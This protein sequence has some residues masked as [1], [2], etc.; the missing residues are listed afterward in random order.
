MKRQIHE[1]SLKLVIDYFVKGY[2]LEE[3]E[4]ICS[5]EY[6]ID[7]G[8]DKMFVALWTKKKDKDADK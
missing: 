8:K 6:Y 1:H 3:G 5:Y 7:Q 4:E 2:K